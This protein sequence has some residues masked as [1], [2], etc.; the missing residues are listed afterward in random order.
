M[1]RH[2]E[3]TAT[4]G[5]PGLWRCVGCGTTR[6]AV[7]GQICGCGEYRSVPVTPPLNLWRR[8]GRHWTW[9]LDDLRSMG[10][11]L[12]ILPFFLLLLLAVLGVL[13]V[14]ARVLSGLARV[15]GG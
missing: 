13:G 14:G 8:I 5:Q 6:P 15:A 9:V 3:R 7:I 1:E 11:A 12:V 10:F 2:W 4:V